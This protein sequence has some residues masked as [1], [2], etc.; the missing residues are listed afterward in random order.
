MKNFIILII[1]CPI[2]TFGQVKSQKT[3]L[4]FGRLCGI[5]SGR[6]IELGSIATEPT[7]FNFSMQEENILMLSCSLENLSS[8]A[9]IAIFNKPL[10]QFI[11]NETLQVNQLEDYI[12]DQEVCAE[13]QLNNSENYG[14]E[15]GNYSA[16]IQNDILFLILT[17]KRILP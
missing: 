14:L 10:N 13:L 7:N 6:C 2:F 9:E 1:L 5:G 3:K 4:R 12:F 11:E 8:A 16:F 15:K 17:I